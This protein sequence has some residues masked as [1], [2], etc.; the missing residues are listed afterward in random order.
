MV[1]ID[2]HGE[3]V[4]GVH[5]LMKTKNWPTPGVK[6]QGRGCTP[7]CEAPGEKKFLTPR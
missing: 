1:L 6:K 3:G 5:P 7:G 2:G 4:M